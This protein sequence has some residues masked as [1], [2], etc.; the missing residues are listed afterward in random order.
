L[1][2]TI[3]KLTLHVGNGWKYLTELLKKRKH[4]QGI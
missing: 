3:E 1:H 4:F 2:A